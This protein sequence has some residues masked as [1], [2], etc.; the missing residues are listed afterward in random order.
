MPANLG[1]S[2]FE[3]A[4]GAIDTADVDDEIAA[5]ETNVT[6]VVT[7]FIHSQELGANP[8]HTIITIES[9]TTILLRLYQ[10]ELDPPIILLDL[11][12]KCAAGEALSVVINYTADTIAGSYYLE[13]EKR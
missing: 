9:G 4:S 10:S 3:H 13:Y 6:F 2:R 5:I 11:E 7:K 1:F 12:L 8:T